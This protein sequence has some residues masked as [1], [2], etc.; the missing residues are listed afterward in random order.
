MGA[1]EPALPLSSTPLASSESPSAASF[2]EVACW[3][4]LEFGVAASPDSSL[5]SCSLFGAPQVGRLQTMPVKLLTVRPC[6]AH[7]RHGL[8]ERSRARK[9]ALM[10]PWLAL[11]P[12]LCAPVGADCVQGL[13]GSS[14]L[15]PPSPLQ[16]GVSQDKEHGAAGRA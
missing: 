7:L 16:R 14:P 11:G 9:P 13:P 1:G 12:S 2:D 5:A 3:S 10:A 4:P 15:A 6:L 8:P